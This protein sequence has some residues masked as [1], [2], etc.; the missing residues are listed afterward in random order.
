MIARL[1]PAA[2]LATLLL[3]GIGCSKQVTLLKSDLEPGQ[4]YDGVELATRGGA[5]RFDRVLVMPD[6]LV[7][8]YHVE[9]QRQSARDGIYYEDVLRKRVVDRDDVVS[10][11]TKKQD[12]ERTLFFGAGVVAAGLLLSDVFDQSLSLGGGSGAAVKAD[13]NRR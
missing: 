12:A 11:T 9:V 3:S 8:E 7:G 4:S 6:S 5:Y 10:L 2:V 1:C 13:P